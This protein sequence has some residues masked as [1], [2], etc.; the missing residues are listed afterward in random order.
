MLGALPIELEDLRMD[1]ATQNGEHKEPRYMLI[2]LALLILTAIEVAV[3]SVGLNRTL[4]IWTL[5][6][7]AIWKAALVALYFMHLRFERLR[8][9]ILALAPVPLA[10]ILVLAVLTEY[11]W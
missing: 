3:A 8:L 2:W 6:G 7:L 5:V 9:V 11:S 1:A 4:L 10:F